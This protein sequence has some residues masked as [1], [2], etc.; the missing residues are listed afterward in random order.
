[1]IANKTL[2]IHKNFDELK[3]TEEVGGRKLY[4]YT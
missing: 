3:K 4:N 1:M 2:I